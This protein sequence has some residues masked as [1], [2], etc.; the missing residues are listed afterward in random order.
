MKWITR[1]RVKVDRVACPWLIKKF[2]DQEAE[3]VFVP[4][5]RVMEE[6]KRLGAI[7]YDVK[8][9][10]WVTTGKNARSRQFSRNTRSSATLRSYCWDG[11]STALIRTTPFTI[12]RKGPV[13]KRLRKASGISDTRTITH[14][15]LRNGSFTTRF[16]PTAKRWS[17]R[18]NPAA[19]SCG[20]PIEA[21]CSVSGGTPQISGRGF[22]PTQDE[23]SRIMPAR[24][25]LPYSCFLL[26]MSGSALAAMA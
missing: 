15:M 24:S 1:E 22:T 11:S 16:T 3:F 20:N 21:C 25:S 9:S 8:T 13:W 18:V 19:S 10:S 14:S 7:P 26:L 5:D 2:V 6:A 23:V 4:A 17:G 12:S